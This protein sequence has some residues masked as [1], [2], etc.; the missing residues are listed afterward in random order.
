MQETNTF[1][2]P[3]FSNHTTN[4]LEAICANEM[5]P[6]IPG[7]MSVSEMEQESVRLYLSEDERQLDVT[8]LALESLERM[9]FSQGKIKQSLARLQKA[10]EVAD[11][12]YTVLRTENTALCIPNQRMKQTVREAEQLTDELEAMQ[13]LLAEKDEALSNLQ[14]HTQ[15]LVVDSEKLNCCCLLFWLEKEKLSLVEQ[16]DTITNEMSSIESAS[17]IDNIKMADLVQIYRSLQ[18]DLE[19]VR[20]SMAQKEEVLLQK[21]FAN[22]QLE[23][24]LSEYTS[25]IQDLKER[26]T[27]LEIQ[28]EEAI[29]NQVD[30]MDYM[31][32]MIAGSRNYVSL[33]AEMSLVPLKMGTSSDEEEQDQSEECE[34]MKPVEAVKEE[35]SRWTHVV[36][37]VKAAGRLTLGL[38]VPLGILAATLP[39]SY[40]HQAGGSC[41]DTFWSAARSLMEPYCTLTYLTPFPV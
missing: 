1:E 12:D 21:D 29:V 20:V 40:E 19:E 33:E 25:I 24:S 41:M 37:G 35:T 17:A 26:I 18:L 27:A 2:L 7:S 10:L 30:Y 9:M 34:E 31:G 16:I 5:T 11:E 32:S 23:R 15:I 39:I 38:L 36:R 6:S 8:D 28:Q 22:K 4:Q 13:S 3:R 14:R